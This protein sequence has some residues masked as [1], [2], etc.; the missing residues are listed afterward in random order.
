MKVLNV[1]FLTMFNSP[2]TVDLLENRTVKGY[3]Y[4]LMYLLIL[5]IND[6][7]KN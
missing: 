7:V 6:I 4:L 2:Q 1:Y 5:S 3:Q